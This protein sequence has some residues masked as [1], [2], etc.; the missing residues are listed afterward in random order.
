MSRRTFQQHQ[1]I[2]NIPRKR[3]G[4][5]RR[6][7]PSAT[8]SEI[9]VQSVDVVAEEEG[10]CKV[11]WNESALAGLLHVVARRQGV[12]FSVGVAVAVGVGVGVA[13]QVSNAIKV[14]GRSMR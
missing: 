12:D 10:C 11:Q 7:A 14:H 9:E 4:C 8:T 2:S 3:R 6:P 1:G 13:V 5:R